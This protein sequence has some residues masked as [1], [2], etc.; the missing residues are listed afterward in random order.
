MMPE[1]PLQVTIDTS[2]FDEFIQKYPAAFDRMMQLTALELIR[3]LGI[4]APTKT[5]RLAG[6]WIL[7]KIREMAYGISSRIPYR[8]WINYGTEPYEIVPSVKQALYFY[9]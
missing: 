9:W 1:N 3:N 6:S 8:F 7:T 2:E 4:E 5:G